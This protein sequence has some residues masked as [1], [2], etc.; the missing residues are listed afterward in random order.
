MIRLK[1]DSLQEGQVLAQDVLRGD[2]VVLI[3]QGKTVTPEVVSLLRRLEVDSV[4]VEG[5]LFDSEEARL[6]HLRMQEDALVERF[7]RVADDPVLKAVRELF[8]RRL[9]DGCGMTNTPPEDEVVSTVQ[10]MQA[11]KS[12]GES[13]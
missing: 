8:R 12:E 3:S 6:E 13:K 11:A 10:D 2:G 1:V 5:D 7:S 4:V 9:R